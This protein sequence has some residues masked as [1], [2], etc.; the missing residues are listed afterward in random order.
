MKTEST[1]YTLQYKTT[2]NPPW[3]ELMFWDDGG[4]YMPFTG[5]TPDELFQQIFEY[6]EGHDE[7]LEAVKKR[8]LDRVDQ[9]KLVKTIKIFE[10]TEED[11]EQYL[12]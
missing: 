2:A 4:H 7:S 8:L 3:R 12:K 1:E 5:E 11:L 9:Y 6:S 10:I